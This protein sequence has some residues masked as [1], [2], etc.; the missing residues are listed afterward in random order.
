MEV[1]AEGSGIVDLTLLAGLGLGFFG[2]SGDGKGKNAIGVC[3]IVECT[4]G[5]RVGQRRIRVSQRSDDRFNSGDNSLVG[6]T[7]LKLI[8]LKISILLNLFLL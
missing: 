1:S 7:I 4:G 5:E 3:A 6:L 8:F 2:L